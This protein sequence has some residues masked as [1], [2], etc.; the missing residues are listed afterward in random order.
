MGTDMPDPTERSFI[1]SFDDN[2]L[3][4]TNTDQRP[5]IWCKKCN[6]ND[7]NNESSARCIGYDICRKNYAKNNN[8]NSKATWDTI[9]D[10]DKQIY[11]NCSNAFINF[12]RYLDINSIMT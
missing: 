6:V 9:K 10:I 7:N 3:N 1:D 11:Y 4:A 12:P 2:Q 8:A 5:Y